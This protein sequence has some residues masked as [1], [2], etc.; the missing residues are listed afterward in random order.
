[1]FA[2]RQ[3]LLKTK[4]SG[5]LSKKK[6]KYLKEDKLYGKQKTYTIKRPITGH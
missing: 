6:L 3:E 2:G 5:F 1:M 4:P